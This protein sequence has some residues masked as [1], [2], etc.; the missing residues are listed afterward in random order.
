VIISCLFDDELGWACE[1][2]VVWLGKWYCVYGGDSWL[3]L[4]CVGIKM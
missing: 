2:T 4:E 1:K 3:F